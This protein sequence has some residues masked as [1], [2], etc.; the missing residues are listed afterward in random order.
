[1]GDEFS[2]ADACLFTVLSWC[3]LVDRDLAPWPSSPAI[4]GGLPSGGPQ[5]CIEAGR[6]T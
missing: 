1:M 2:V 4:S 5:G 3:R 6:H